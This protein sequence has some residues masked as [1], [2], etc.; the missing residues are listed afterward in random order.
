MRKLTRLCFL[1]CTALLAGEAKA[2]IKLYQ[3]D[4]SVKVYA[5][6]KEQT[7]AWSGGFNN[8]QFSMADVNDD[9]LKD[10]VVFEPWNSVRTFINK[11]TTG[12]PNYRYAPEY[13]NNFP[14]CYSYCIL[15]DYNCDGI[16]DL[17]HRG[18]FG[19][20]VYTG[21]FNTGHQLCFRFFKDL[22]YSN[23]P[24]THGPSNAYSN[25][26][27]IPAAVDL[28]N[29]GDLDFVSFDITGGT[30][31]MYKNMRVE[32]GLP[33]DSL[34]IE[35][36][37]RCWGKV[38]QGFY[39]THILDRS[40]DNSGL[41]ES[42]GAEKPTHSGNTPCLFDWDMDGDYDVLDGSVS[43]NEMTFMKNGRIENSW[44]VDS[45]VSQDTM[46][47]SG[48]KRIE[49]STWPAAFNVDVDQDGKKDLL[50]G[51]NGLGNSENYNC[52]WYYKNLSTTG[53]PNWQFQSDSFLVDKS[54]DLGSSANPVLFDYNKDG[55]LDLFIGSDG[56]RQ[57]TGLLSSRMS[58]Y[59]NT[60][61]PGNMSF[62][63]VTK[64][65]MGL[66]TRSFV[67]IAPTFGDIDFDGKKD[68]I[69]GHSDGTISYYK[70]IATADSVTPD[71]QLMQLNLLDVN[72][73][74]IT[75]DGTAMPF[76]YDI[77]KDGKKDLLI[78][79]YFGN[80]NY[81]Q[82]ISA[83]PGAIRLKLITT[84]LGNAK[85]DPKIN[86]GNN[87][88]P[89]IG[90]IDSTGVEYLMMGSGSGLIYRYTGFQGGDT[91]A[92]YAM[93]DS[94]Y[95]F[96]DT[97]HSLYLNP[98]SPQGI[99]S[100]LRSTLAVGDIGNDGSYEMLV[101]NNKG[102]IE[103][104]KWKVRNTV[105]VPTVQEEPRITVF[106]NPADD[107]IN[108]VWSDVLQSDVQISI[109]NMQGQQLLSGVYPS[110]Y[111]QTTISIA[112]LPSGMYICQLLTGTGRYFTKFT[113]VK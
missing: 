68:M 74:I 33:C 60:S 86:G 110:A 100:N 109:I 71:W 76:I 58:Y 36:K 11:G 42:G 27:D 57:P 78:G 88:A 96:I 111:Y 35:L 6:G 9:G 13:G 79:D 72:G 25:P 32:R 52:I 43:F 94:A 107:K 51:P 81:Y 8:P 67:G 65:F 59:K 93:I 38:Y 95:S 99:Y 12:N 40:C 103:L 113:V 97:V 16:S 41:K 84:H 30:V 10:L 77:D 21:Y 19:F 17:V 66:S 82:N 5:Y 90:V 31:N 73:D 44:P 34:L 91:A 64:D 1:L 23:D 46:W 15:A 106:P 29:D 45:M 55:K 54:I 48:G 89:F 69:I 61:V 20:A 18:N 87:A 98:G 63:L 14:A 62:E 37:D 105:N 2:E 24:R 39:R 104:Y 4:T 108:I 7:L 102:G 28:D 49:L 85:A 70:N 26:G 83:T 50:I 101:G 92:T 22:F 53:S 80:I 47:Q 112:S 3:R 75:V 56:Y